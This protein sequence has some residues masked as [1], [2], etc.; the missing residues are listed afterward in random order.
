[1]TLQS[2]ST[3]SC[4][5]FPVNCIMGA[6]EQLAVPKRTRLIEARIIGLQSGGAEAPRSRVTRAEVTTALYGYN[7]AGLKPGG[8][9][10]EG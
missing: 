4:Q 2:H 8:P 7:P 3:E 9:S 1:M 10:G 6:R 5:S